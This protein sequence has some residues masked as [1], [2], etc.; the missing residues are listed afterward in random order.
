MHSRICAIV[1]PIFHPSRPEQQ[2]IYLVIWFGGDEMV[3]K[4]NT[5]LNSASELKASINETLLPDLVGLIYV[6][7]LD[8]SKS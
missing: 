1:W 3:A 5:T 8:V 4:K 7:A 2:G 6:F